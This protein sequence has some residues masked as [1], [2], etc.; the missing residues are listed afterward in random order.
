MPLDTNG[1]S[2]HADKLVLL[3]SR[4][5][6]L[7]LSDSSTEFPTRQNESSLP[8]LVAQNDQCT[9]TIALQGA[10]LLTFKNHATAAVGSPETNLLWLSPTAIFKTGKA[11]RGGIPLCLPWFGPHNSDPA[12]PQHGFARNRPWSLIDAQPVNAGTTQLTWELL[13]PDPQ[14][15]SELDNALFE[16]SFRVHLT[17]TLSNVIELQLTVSNTGTES[18][19]L[20]WALHSYH[21]VA[22]IST[23]EVAGLDQCEYLDNTDWEDDLEN[24][25]RYPAVKCRKR[26]SGHVRFSGEVDRAYVSVPEKQQLISQKTRLS[27]TATNSHS[28]II[29][30]PGEEVATTMADIGAEHY[31]G[32]VCIERGNT[33]DNTLSLPP[34]E[35]H[36]A[37]VSISIESGS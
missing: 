25:N 23:A 34:G 7:H 29:W 5:A 13:Y 32:F 33:A 6:H 10:Q 17:M 27:V 18:F 30:N 4:C 11:I 26:Q 31:R 36:S 19:P 35:S 12:K 22:D 1:Q 20:S 9:A 21:P 37:S 3:L 8:L 14:N 15:P 24:D 2:T 16:G 28:A